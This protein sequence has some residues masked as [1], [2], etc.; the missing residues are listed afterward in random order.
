MLLPFGSLLLFT[1][2]RRS[3][4]EKQ[5][6]LLSLSVFALLSVGVMAGCSGTSAPA[7]QPPAATSPTPTPTPGTPMGQSQI[8]ITATAGAVTQS[9]VVSLT[10]Q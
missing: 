6:F 1:N 3:G 7:M 9:T 10:V 8:T 4:K 5:L 2:R